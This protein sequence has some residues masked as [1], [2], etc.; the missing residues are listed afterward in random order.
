MENSN[1]RSVAFVAWS[2]KDSLHRQT[3][4]F[5]L[6][7]PLFCFLLMGKPSRERAGWDHFQGK[8]CVLKWNSHCHSSECYEERNYK[9][10]KGNFN[11]PVN[12]QRGT[13][14]FIKVDMLPA[15]W[16]RAG[17]NIV[18]SRSLWRLSAVGT[19]KS[20]LHTRTRSRSNFDPRRSC[21]AH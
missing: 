6:F 15:E 16:V 13:R 8:Q 21:R 10:E 12:C 14:T 19:V 7:F 20:L 17:R 9:H 2:L 1:K 3:S 18:R 5:F 11:L 4:I